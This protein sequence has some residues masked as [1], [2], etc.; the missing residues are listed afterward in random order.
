MK[1]HAL[2]YSLWNKFRHFES[3]RDVS[4]FL[5]IPL[6]WFVLPCTL[7]LPIRTILRLLTPRCQ[8]FDWEDSD[9]HQCQKI[10]RFAHYWFQR[11]WIAR[12]NTC[13]KTSLLLYYFLNREGIPTRIYF[14]IKKNE[15]NL[16]GHSWIEPQFS[17]MV[18][19]DYK[20]DFVEIYAYPERPVEIFTTHSTS[21]IIQKTNELAE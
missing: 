15:D 7:F 4:L 11:T 8:S 1:C 16:S 10:L 19:P 3:L 12:Q 5:Q 6:F 2:S 17:D 13:L 18:N 20:N 21:S 14:G 9:R